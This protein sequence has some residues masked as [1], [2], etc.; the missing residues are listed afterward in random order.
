MMQL[1]WVLEVLASEQL[2]VLQKQDSKLHAS[3]NSSQPDLT[4]SQLRVELMQRLVTCMKMI[5]ATISMTL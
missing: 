4:L 1:L 3:Q 2:L 5:G